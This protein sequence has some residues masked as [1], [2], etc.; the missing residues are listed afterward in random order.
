MGDVNKL[1]MENVDSF[2]FYLVKTNCENMVALK[3]V[4]EAIANL[5]PIGDPHSAYI[6]RVS[7]VGF[8]EEAPYHIVVSLFGNDGSAVDELIRKISEDIPG[9]LSEQC[10]E[11]RLLSDGQY[12]AIST[13]QEYYVPMNGER[14]GGGDNN[15]G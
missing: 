3:I 9:V 2:R 7:S 14:P 8:G 11:L 1:E 4:A 15:W 12:P 10:M 13:T 6:R 5:L